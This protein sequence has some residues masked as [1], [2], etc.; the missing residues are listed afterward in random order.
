MI[1]RGCLKSPWSTFVLPF[2]FLVVNLKYLTTKDIEGV[3]KQ[4]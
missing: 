4:L 1:K 2:V 3:H